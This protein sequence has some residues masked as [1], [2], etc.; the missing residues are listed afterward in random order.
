MLSSACQSLQKKKCFP[1]GV[2][3]SQ[4]AP[5]QRAF[6]AWQ[7]DYD[8]V[9]SEPRTMSHSIHK[10][11]CIPAGVLYSQLDP[12]QS[13]SCLA[14]VL[15]M[16]LV[17]TQ[18]QQQPFLYEQCLQLL[19]RLAEQLQTRDAMLTLLRQ[20]PFN[21][22]ISQIGQVLPAEDVQQLQVCTFTVTPLKTA[23][24]PVYFLSSGMTCA[25]T[26][27]DHQPCYVHVP[28]SSRRGCAAIAGLQRSS[29]KMPF[30]SV[31]VG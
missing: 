28:S 25:A 10:D 9:S 7:L 17:P 4:W 18:P 20:Q 12:Q 2:L 27:L 11:W 3:Y 1:A 5:Q 8:R 13:F 15:D 14:V 23:D 22:L 6:P 26:A 21:L 19:Y 29:R 31:V 24:N 30:E 16:A